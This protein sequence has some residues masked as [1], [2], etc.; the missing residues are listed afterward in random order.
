[1]QDKKNFTRFFPYIKEHTVSKE[2]YALLKAIKEYYATYPSKDSFT[3]GDMKMFFFM[4]H[5]KASPESSVVYTRMFEEVEKLELPTDRDVLDAVMHH[6]IKQDYATQAFNKLHKLITNGDGELDDIEELIADYRKEIGAAISYDELF[7]STKLSEVS[8]K[9][10]TK[11]YNWRLNELNKSLGPLR[12]GNFVILAARP[13]TGKTTMTA[14]EVTFIASQLPNDD[15][16]VIWVNNE[17][18][19]DTVM[20]RII[21]AYHGVTAEELMKNLP[22][23]EEEYDKAIGKRIRVIGDDSGIDTVTKLSSLFVDLNPA[24]I[25]FDQLDKVDGFYKSEREDLRIGQLYKWARTL[26]KKYG[27]VIAVSQVDGSGE[28]VEWIQM[29]QLRGSKTDKVGEADAIITIGKSND[30]HKEFDRFI[31]VPKNK[32][33]GGSLSEERF[34]HG[35][36]EVKIQP[37]IA[38]YKGVL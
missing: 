11:G 13:E 20:M 18:P 8:K 10:L 1:M 2:F 6:F 19:N 34:R 4:L 37:E 30:P 5:S 21:Q 26:A 22:K 24:V 28:G 31:H 27:L 14:S 32:L 25:V 38:R 35:Y 33:F 7:A 23:Y 29:N 36:F 16:P 17:E 3:W 9:A 15:R 12:E